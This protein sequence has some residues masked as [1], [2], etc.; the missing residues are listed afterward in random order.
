MDGPERWLPVA[1]LVYVVI[2]VAVVLYMAMSSNVRDLRYEIGD[3]RREIGAV[4][5]KIKYRA[6]QDDRDVERLLSELRRSR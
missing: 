5:R 3:L 1:V 6:E 2:M 4:Q